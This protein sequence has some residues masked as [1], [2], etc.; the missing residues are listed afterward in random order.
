MNNFI[1][2]MLC[3]IKRSNK[4]CVCVCDSSQFGLNKILLKIVDFFLEEIN[5]LLNKRLI[6]K[7]DE[8]KILILRIEV[9]VAIEEKFY[10]QRT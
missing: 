7:D 9:L 2:S 6:K 4:L 1:A 5:E 10:V 8:K 3:E